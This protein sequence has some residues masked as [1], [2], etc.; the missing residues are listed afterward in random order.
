MNGIA[1]LDLQTL[2]RV[3]AGSSDQSLEPREE[4]GGALRSMSEKGCPSN[5]GHAKLHLS[6]VS[7][8]F[9]H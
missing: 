7:P 9:A 4:M 8:C 2:S 3:E 1:G 6:D 5:I